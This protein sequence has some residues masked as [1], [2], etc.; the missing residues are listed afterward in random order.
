MPE[1]ASL[2]GFVG[3]LQPFLAP[4]PLDALAVDRKAVRVR[5][6]VGACSRSGVSSWRRRPAG[7]AARSPRRPSAA[8]FS[9]WSGSGRRCSGRPGAR[10]CPNGRSGDRPFGASGPGLE[11]SPRHLFES[12][13]VQLLV[14]DNLFELA[15]FFLKLLEALGVVDLQAAVLAVI[16]KHVVHPA[17]AWQAGGV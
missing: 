7:L 16:S 6:R 1:P 11:F 2:L 15:V 13:D 4:D 17:P 10:R 5:N 3:D 12:P 14:G 9:A 8:S